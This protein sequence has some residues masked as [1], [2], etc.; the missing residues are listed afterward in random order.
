M[1]MKSKQP[2]VKGPGDWFTGASGSTASSSPTTT[3]RS[4]SVLSTSHPARTAW[5][6]HDGGQT[7]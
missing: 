5:H 4:M 7:L 6:A 1:E 3:P 2:T